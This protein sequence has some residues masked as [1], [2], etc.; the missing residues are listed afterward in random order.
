VALCGA[1]MSFYPSTPARSTA[2]A[3]P[4]SALP[5]TPQ[6]G[7]SMSMAAPNTSASG[8]RS[9]VASILREL[10][11]H[12]TALAFQPDEG[13]H[14]GKHLDDSVAV[15]F[16]GAGAE[17]AAVVVLDN[18]LVVLPAHGRARTVRLPLGEHSV[19]CTASV[20]AASGGGRPGLLLAM[21]LP[22]GTAAAVFY[23]DPL[24]DEVPLT[25]ELPAAN[26]AT[27]LSMTSVPES[28]GARVFLGM[29]D[30]TILQI[31]LGARSPVCT[32]FA[33]AAAGGVIGAAAEV[34]SSWLG[35]WGSTL[36]GAAAPGA[37]TPATGADAADAAPGQPIGALAVVES[38]G[39]SVLVGLSVGAL[40]FWD[41]AS[42]RPLASL[43]APSGLGELRD[44][45]VRSNGADGGPAALAILAQSDAGFVL[46]DLVSRP[47]V[48]AAQLHCSFVLS[49]LQ[50]SPDCSFFCLVR[51]VQIS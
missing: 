39:I 2:A 51:P 26:R 17:A 30:G 7:G 41:I 15:H 28:G 21:D 34:A 47:V 19:G 37:Q 46:C 4:A 22:T 36:L 48:R 40:Q 43:D 29:S 27:C 35:G 32:G 18:K 38:N 33:Q 1:P 8:W 42:E 45:A 20:P 9:E 24:Y 44:L 50:F 3:S 14:E 13:D 12:K 11:L 49:F 16:G 6:L 25:V 5:P 23:A 31:S 10:H